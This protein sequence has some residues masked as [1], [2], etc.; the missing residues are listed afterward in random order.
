MLF[1]L[2]EEE[3]KTCSLCTYLEKPKPEFVLFLWLSGDYQQNHPLPCE[4]VYQ[5]EG[6]KSILMYSV[7]GIQEKCIGFHIPE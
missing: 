6:D 7:I 4:K 2:E 3:N 1:E 5:I